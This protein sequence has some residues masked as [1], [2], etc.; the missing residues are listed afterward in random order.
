MVGTGVGQLFALS[1]TIYVADQT[2]TSSDLDAVL[3]AMVLPTFIANLLINSIP[4]VLVAAYVDVRRR[5]SRQ[6]AD[7]GF[8]VLVLTAAVGGLGTAATLLLFPVLIGI[9]GP[10]LDAQAQETAVAA[11]PFVAPS[12]LF[13]SLAAVFGA[14]CQGTGRFGILALAWAIGPAAGVVTVVTTW[15]AI[16]AAALGASQTMTFLVTLLVAAAPVVLAGIVRP[17]PASGHK[18]T[19]RIVRSASPIATGTFFSQFN[20]LVDRSLASLL[21]VGSVSALR[22]GEQ[23]ISAPVRLIVPGGSGALIPALAHAHAESGASSD[24]VGAIVRSSARWS[25]VLLTPA[26]AGAAALAPLV[27][28]IAYGRGAFDLEAQQST[29][30]AVA[31]FAPLIVLS[32]LNAVLFAAL[33]AVGR[34]RSIGLAAIVQAATN[35]ILDVALG[36]LLGVAGIALATSIAA[37]VSAAVM[38]VALRPVLSDPGGFALRRSALQ[39]LVASV[40]PAVPIAYVAWTFGFGPADLARVVG[41]VILSALGL[42]IYAF[43][44]TAL[45]LP[46]PRRL[47]ARLQAIR[48]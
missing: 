46:E 34:T 48:P 18:G 45:G 31:G 26:A 33:N 19:L 21:A 5:D 43:L 15:P 25:L 1:R 40:V 32:M 10:G 7:L 27:V 4:A 3:V 30:L 37:A 12:V 8:R 11:M 28:S 41:L 6:A 24:R 44:A 20:E 39:A 36:R 47:A 14:L 35:L 22:Y 9:L 29:S 17:V 16:G 2:G 38:G 23:L 42:L 13:G